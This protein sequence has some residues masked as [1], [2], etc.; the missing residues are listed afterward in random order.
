MV[1]LAFAGV[2]QHGI[3]TGLASSVSASRC[4]DG[5]VSREEFPSGRCVVVFPVV[6]AACCG[7]NVGCRFWAP[8]FFLL[9]GAALP[10]HDCL[11]EAHT[12]RS[13][14]SGL[15]LCSEDGHALVR[16]SPQKVPSMQ[17]ITQTAMVVLTAFH[18][19]PYLSQR[20][21][22]ITELAHSCQ[23]AAYAAVRHCE[24]V[25]LLG[26]VSTSVRLRQ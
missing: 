19:A 24:R 5:A 23:R 3:S 16:V 21:H 8:A 12:E 1:V 20:R 6:F 4:Q 2:L 15:L 13:V 25:H 7:L 10:A 26:R 14:L 22:S 11:F 9:R 18:V 17:A